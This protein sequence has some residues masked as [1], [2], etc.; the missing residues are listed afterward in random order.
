[1]SLRH[2]SIFMLSRILLNS[3]YLH[4]SI[5]LLFTWHFSR[6]IVSSSSGPLKKYRR[7]YC[8]TGKSVMELFDYGINIIENLTIIEI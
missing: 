6:L 5:R 4:V 3:M 2:N 8:L 1:M 7:K